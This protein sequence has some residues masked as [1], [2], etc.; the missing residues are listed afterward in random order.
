MQ[1]NNIKVLKGDEAE[2]WRVEH[3][4]NS[5]WNKDAEVYSKLLDKE[6]V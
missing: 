5:V 1:I 6:N 4:T 3:L 2:K